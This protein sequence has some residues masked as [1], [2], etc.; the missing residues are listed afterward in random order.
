MLVPYV[1]R[2]PWTKAKNTTLSLN[3]YFIKF[4]PSPADRLYKDFGLF[5]KTPLP[6]EAARMELDLQ[7]A[8]G[9]SVLTKIVPCGTLEFTYNEVIKS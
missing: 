6:Q 3:S 4:N 9:R 2:E 8:R 5:L 7:L 1:L